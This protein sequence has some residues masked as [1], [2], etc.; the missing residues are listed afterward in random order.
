VKIDVKLFL[1]LKCYIVSL[2]LGNMIYQEHQI[3]WNSGHEIVMCFKS[4]E[5][6]LKNNC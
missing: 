4:S 2:Q 1:K 6:A 5:L 3:L